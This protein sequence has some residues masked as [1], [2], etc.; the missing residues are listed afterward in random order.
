MVF[1]RAWEWL[2]ATSETRVPTRDWQSHSVRSNQPVEA[3]GQISGNAEWPTSRLHDEGPGF[4][5]LICHHHVDRDSVPRSHWGKQPMSE[6]PLAPRHEFETPVSDAGSQCLKGEEAIGD[7][8][9][10]NCLGPKLRRPPDDSI[11]RAG[12]RRM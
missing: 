2:S 11:P 5:D 4:D 10:K 6:S 3:A 7:G 1:G 8:R 12:L 9:E